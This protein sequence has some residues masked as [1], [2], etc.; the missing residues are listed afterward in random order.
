VG[1]LG[2]WSTIARITG[3]A[4]QPYRDFFGML[5]PVTVSK[6]S[7]G[8]IQ[9][10]GAIRET[11]T[12][13]AGAASLKL[14][15]AGEQFLMRVP[16]TAVSTVISLYVYR[17][18]DYAGSLPQMIIRQPGQAD[19]ITTDAGSASAWNQLSDTFTPAS[20]PPYVDLFIRSRNTAVAGSY[21]VYY[22]TL[23]V[24]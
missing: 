19:R 15:D 21:S 5:R 4:Y 9:A 22:D 17:E 20:L 11:G 14:P 8:S 24:S 7:S 1:D 18:A 2:K 16:I 6:N 10:T 3:T 13:Q 12:V 23:S